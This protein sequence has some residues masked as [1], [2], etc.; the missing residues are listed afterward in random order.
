MFDY[1]VFAL[2]FPPNSNLRGSV[3]HLKFFEDGAVD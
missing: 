2:I 1:I 3:L